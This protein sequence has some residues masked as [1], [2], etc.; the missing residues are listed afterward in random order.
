MP[1]GELFRLIGDGLPCETASAIQLCKSAQR[2][3]FLSPPNFSEIQPESVITDRAQYVGELL[4]SELA[5]SFRSRFEFLFDS[6]RCRDTEG[7]S[8]VVFIGRQGSFSFQIIYC[9]P[10]PRFLLPALTVENALELA[11]VLARFITSFAEAGY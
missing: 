11:F 6:G 9:L 1:R 2:I 7:E 10:E 4:N 3:A 5:A 8:L